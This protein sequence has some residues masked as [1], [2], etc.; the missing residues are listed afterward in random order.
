MHSPCTPLRPLIAIQEHHVSSLQN[1]HAVMAFILGAALLASSPSSLADD[2]IERIRK[3]LTQKMRNV[4]VGAI[5]RTPHAG[6][7]EVVANGYSVFYTNETGEIAFLGKLVDLN[8]QTN[9]SDA[10]V[11]EL[12]VVDF[13]QLPLEKAIVKVK[14]S[15]ARKMALF[16]DPDCP[17]CVELEKEL[18]GITDV[19]IYTFL[20][21]IAEIHPD[22]IRKATLVWC[23]SDRVKAWDDL[24]LRRQLPQ[25]GTQCETPIWDIA[26]LAKKLWIT[27]TPGM[28]FGNGQLVPGVL[29]RQRIEQLLASPG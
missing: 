26:D 27:G 11:R 24:M 21:P 10:R 8:T 14:G 12:S 5:T 20:Y 22:A 28:I 13:A 29:P 19:T 23:S 7:Y 15:G 3:S 9:I 16:S 6:L 18:E 4:Q 17:Y 1:P 2:N 25:G